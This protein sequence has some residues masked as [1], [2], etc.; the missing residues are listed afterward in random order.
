MIHQL[1]KS[2]KQPLV[3]VKNVR[4]DY[5]K[6]YPAISDVNFDVMEGDFIG[7]IG[8]NGG[9]KSTLLKIMMGILPIQQGTVTLFGTEIRK[10][11]QWNKIGYVSQKATHFDKRFPATVKEIVAMGRIQTRGIFNHL[12]KEDYAAC[13]DALK[14][15]GMLEYENR[16]LYEL[17]GGQQQRVFIARAIASHPKLLVLDEPTIG[18]DMK[19][20][21]QFYELLKKLRQEKGLT[22]ILVSHDI[23]VIASQVNNYVCIN[24]T[25]IY[26]GEPEEFA[27]NDYMKKLY[28]KNIRMVLHGH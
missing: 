18:I 28:G 13:S 3:S 25:L 27:R 22:I 14:E 26:H 23:D 20:Q 4:Y 7:M 19:A 5:V 2:G 16:P 21:E 15:V 24:Q 6:G 12:K 17:S 11:K 8:P 1:E 9:G 10:F